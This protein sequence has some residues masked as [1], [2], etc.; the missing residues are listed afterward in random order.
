MGTSEESGDQRGE[1]GPAGRV[2]TSGESE[3]DIQT[4]QPLDPVSCGRFT[5]NIAKMV[6]YLRLI[7]HLTWG[8]AIL[9]VWS[10]D[11]NMWE[12]LSQP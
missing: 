4:P 6:G 8:S 11:A 10:V 3:V 2:G 9:S 1:W 7:R 5:P 12:K